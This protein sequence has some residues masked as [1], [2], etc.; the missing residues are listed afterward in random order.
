MHAL[1]SDKEGLLMELKQLKEIGCASFAAEKHK[2]ESQVKS[3]LDAVAHADGKLVDAEK[4]LDVLARRVNELTA[5]KV[6]ALERLSVMTSESAVVKEE[7]A[8]MMA[9]HKNAMEELTNVRK[10]Y[11]TLG[12]RFDM[13][14]KEI[15]VL[16]WKLEV[17]PT[18][19]AIFE[20]FKNSSTWKKLVAEIRNDAIAEYKAS[21]DCVTAID[22]AVQAFC[23][24]PQFH[25]V[26][27][28][29]TKVMLPYLVESCRDYFRDDPQRS[30][31]GFEIF[32]VDW[33]R[34]HNA[35]KLK[36]SVESKA[37]SST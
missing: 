12:N 6:D 19:E 26:V 23:K 29:K 28:E 24:S 37:P 5:E 18:R 11:D 21:P 17:V 27:G 3:G 33:K 14:E 10:D 36:G 4:K 7:L 20:E 31:E 34:R 2:L 30:R 8:A 32:F 22:A 15:E 35:E 9:N 13:S 16:K 1:E 25:R